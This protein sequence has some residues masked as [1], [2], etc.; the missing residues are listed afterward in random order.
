MNPLLLQNREWLIK[1]EALESLSATVD[2]FFKDGQSIQDGTTD[3]PVMSIQ[4]GIA[5]ISID[6]PLMRNPGILARIFM[7]AT[8][9]TMILDAIVE[10]TD[11]PDVKAVMLDI[12]SPGGT[13]SGT[14]E[15]AAAV[16]DLNKAKPVYAFSAGMMC[17]AAYW[18][19]SQ[20]RAIYVT[21]SATVGSIGV[22]QAVVDKTD[23]LAKQ[24][25]KVEVFTVG[26]F[27]AMGAP[28]VPLT[29]DQRALI[30]SNLGEIAQEFHDAVLSNGRKVPADAMEGQTFRGKQAE[31]V[32]L[33]KVVKNRA[34]AFERLGTYVAA[35]DTKARSKS[36]TN[37]FATM[38]LEEQLAKLQ[39]DHTA[40]SELL[41]EAAAN[42]ANAN[43]RVSALSAS[44]VT[45]KDELATANTTIATLQGEVAT[46][47]SD[48][49]TLEKK[50]ARVVAGTGTTTAASTGT[51]ESDAKILTRPE[52]EKLDHNA[53]HAFCVSGGRITD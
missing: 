8:D 20:A 38:T 36:R 4:D 42:L 30:Q 1:P 41:T 49:E 27:K 2:A 28:G 25:V 53:R 39:A 9:S 17:S 51:Q 34:E 24:G 32:N 44:L 52:F 45:V 12:D 40:Q 46:L 5:T 35:V 26:K 23:A 31:R 43:T 6:G 15:M 7:G 18:I 47:N 22:V 3:N 16:A 37:Q 21:P 48:K 10:A 50:V 29:E 11:R 14:P 13:V 33:A 19:A